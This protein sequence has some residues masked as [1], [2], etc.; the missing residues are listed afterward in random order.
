VPRKLVLITLSN[1][2]TSLFA[3]AEGQNAS[4]VYHHIDLSKFLWRLGE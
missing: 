4:V 3:I 2:A 1:V